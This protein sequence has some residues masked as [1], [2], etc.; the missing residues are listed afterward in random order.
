MRTCNLCVPQPCTLL[1]ALG[2]PSN[3]TRRCLHNK[4]AADI[5]QSN[6]IEMMNVISENQLVAA[7][8]KFTLYLYQTLAISLKKNKNIERKKQ[9]HTQCQAK[10]KAVRVREH[11]TA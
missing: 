1:K 9:N 10:T 11:T 8:T 2:V 7:H 4:L 3:N 5:T 6:G